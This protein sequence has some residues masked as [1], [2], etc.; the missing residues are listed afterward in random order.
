MT[1]GMVH[2]NNLTPPGS[3]NPYLRRRL[4]RRRRHLRF[5]ERRHGFRRA[6]LRRVV[7][8]QDEFVKE[9]F[10]TGFSLYRPKCCNQVLSS[11]RG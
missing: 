10:E 4:R 8:V 5:L 6:L 2:V 9:N 3:A 11:S 7:A 1:A